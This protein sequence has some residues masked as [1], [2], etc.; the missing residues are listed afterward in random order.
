MGV[1]WA[2]RIQPDVG[3]RTAQDTRWSPWFVLPHSLELIG[4]HVVFL[5]DTESGHVG[6]AAQV[7]IPDHVA[8][9]RGAAWY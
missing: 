7:Q 8:V 3:A 2:G 9:L 6:R 4:G 1:T 5:I